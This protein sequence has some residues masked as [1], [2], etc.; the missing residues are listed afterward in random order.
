MENETL[1]KKQKA[2]ARVARFRSRCHRIDYAPSKDVQAIIESTRAKYP[3]WN[4]QTTIDALIRTANKHIT[5]NGQG[6]AG[7]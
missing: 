1:S 2:N 5:G 7:T 3:D 4:V 6:Q